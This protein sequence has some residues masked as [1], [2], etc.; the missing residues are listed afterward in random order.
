MTFTQ[1]KFLSMPLRRQHKYAG[2]Y[3]RDLY[4]KGVID[5]QYRQMESWLELPPLSTNQEAMADRFHL[6][7]KTAAVSIQE[8]HLLV[9]RYDQISTAPYGTVGVYLEGLRSAHNI[10]SILRTVEAFR[11]GPVYFSTSTPFAD[12]PKVIKTAMGTASHVPCER[13][14]LEDLPK[15]L[16]ALET[17]EGAPS[18]FDFTFP[19]AFTLLLGNEE[20]GLSK[21]AIERADHVVK[22]SLLG[23]KNSLNVACAFAIA[24]AQ[25]CNNFSRAS[26][27]KYLS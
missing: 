18:L 14:N 17:V 3:L 19:K 27:E 12:H 22:I 8:H 24:A 11:L 4:D 2:E 25:L 21:K 26:G 6:H 16:I 10:G 1:N 13:K 5:H 20:Y 7:M 23:S 15:P 9:K